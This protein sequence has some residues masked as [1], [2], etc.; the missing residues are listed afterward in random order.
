[1]VAALRVN[2]HSVRCVVRN[3]AKTRAALDMHGLASDDEIDVATADL[4]DAAALRS[5]LDGV[6]AV[7]HTAALFSLNPNDAQAMAEVNPGSVK[8]IIGLVEEL[9]LTKMVYVSTMG[10]YIPV[11][12]DHVDME[13][14]LSPGCGPYTYSKIAAEKVARAAI[15]KGAPVVSVYPGAVLGPFDPNPD[16]SDSQVVIRDALKGKIP[17]A[18]KNSNL[19]LIDVRDVAA[20]CAG[21]VDGGT[22]TRYLVPG[23]TLLLTDVWSTLNDMT[24]NNLKLR[25]APPFMVKMMAKASDVVSK[26][27]K[28]KMPI[29]DETVKILI[30]GAESV[31]TTYGWMPAQNDF[32]VPRFD[33]QTTLRD[34]VVWLHGAGHIEDKHVGKLAD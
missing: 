17:M 32:G 30:A 1:M 13:S 23:Q 31:D 12:G 14:P 34:A 25:N 26:L 22:S 21:A 5:A 27:T 33:P 3:V 2:G 18:L 10:V 29:T 9:G 11:A 6:D 19:P 15:E 8:T 4:T 7:V 20:V 16:L 24:G 28:R